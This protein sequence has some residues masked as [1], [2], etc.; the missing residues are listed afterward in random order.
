[1]NN[2]RKVYKSH[3]Y[4]KDAILRQVLDKSPPK[5]LIKE[6]TVATQEMWSKV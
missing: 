4:L 5:Q 6:Q 3:A 1:M 2:S